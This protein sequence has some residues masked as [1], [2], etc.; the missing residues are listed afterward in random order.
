MEAGKLTV[1]KPKKKVQ[2]LPRVPAWNC[3]C[4][5]TTA[6]KP[7][8]TLRRSFGS[9]TVLLVDII[10]SFL[11]FSFLKL[12]KHRRAQQSHQLPCIKIRSGDNASPEGER[13]TPA[14]RAI[15]VGNDLPL[16]I[17]IYYIFKMW[18]GVG[19]WEGGGEKRFLT[20]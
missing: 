4:L 15:S 5:L 12:A 1:V 7:H 11:F 18:E 9:N 3:H 14:M 19:V 2:L 6:G 20:S 13:A 10:F 17:Y 8:T 16:S